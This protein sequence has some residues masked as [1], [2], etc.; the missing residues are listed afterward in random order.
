MIQLLRANGADVNGRNI[1]G[2]TPVTLA[3]SIANYDVRQ[4]F[5]DTPEGSN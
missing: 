2:V 4:W 3:R 5:T 1:H